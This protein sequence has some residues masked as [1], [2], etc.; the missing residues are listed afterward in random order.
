MAGGN[1]KVVIRAGECSVSILPAF[2]GKIASLRVMDCELLQSPL[3]PYAVR[4]RTMAFEESDAS[5]WDECLPS[6]SACRVETAGGRGDVPD[7]GDLWRVAWQVMERT[8]DSAT[9]TGE[10]L[11]FPLSLTRTM[12]LGETTTGWRLSMLYSL[13]NHGSH[14]V[15][16][17]WAAHPLFVCEEGDRICLPESVTSVRVENSKGQRL[18][19]S[20]AWINW[21][22]AELA[23]GERDDLSY[24]KASGSGT[25]EKLFTGRLDQAVGGGA[26]SGNGWC[27]LERVRLGLRLTIRFDARVTPYL[28]LWLCD[29]GWPEMDGARQTC[30]ALEPTTA[31]VDS[32]AVDGPWSRALDP[33]VT[34]HWPM[35]LCIDRVTGDERNER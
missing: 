15:P 26:G 7:H 17:S 3:K 18:G 28:G 6:V 11:T 30:V 29:G 9:I 13:T 34:V 1:E 16:W 24:A 12:L 14:A 5:G 31:P 27:A 4:N 21:P 22:V 20:G 8:E 33:G 25:A 10:C 23:G 32:L 2:G 35:E 19:D